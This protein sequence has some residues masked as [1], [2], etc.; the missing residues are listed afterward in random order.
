MSL[1]QSGM[2]LNRSRYFSRRFKASNWLNLATLRN[3]NKN[4]VSNWNNSK[5]LITARVAKRAKVMFLHVSVILS[6][7]G[8]GILHQGRS[9]GRRPSQIW[10]Q[11]SLRSEDRPPPSQIRVQTPR[12]LRS[13]GRHPSDQGQTPMSDQ[14][15]DPPSDQRADPPQI[16]GQTPGG[17]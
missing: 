11:T 5:W 2:M 17:R 12:P 13:E 3:R 8:G 14:R 7:F 1:S 9:E 16:R 10:G 6:H 15:A 4:S